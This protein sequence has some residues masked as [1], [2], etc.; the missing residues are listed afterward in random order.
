NRSS[1]SPRVAIATVTSG[2]TAVYAR[3]YSALSRSAKRRRRLPASSRAS[4]VTSGRSSSTTVRTALSVSRC[5]ST[6]PTSSSTRASRRATADERVPAQ[7][8]GCAQ[9]GKRP[10][11]GPGADRARR[12]DHGLWVHDAHRLPARRAEDRPERLA[13][14]ADADD[15]AAGRGA[16]PD[17]LEPVAL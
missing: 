11:D 17:D 4:A 14:A 1:R 3:S 13:V 5:C 2:S 16:R 6:R 9:H 12:A 10:H 15:G 7:P 8:A